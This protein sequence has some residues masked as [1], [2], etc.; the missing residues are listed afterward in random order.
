MKPGPVNERIFFPILCCLGTDIE[1]QTDE[2]DGYV[3]FPFCRRFFLG[4]YDQNKKYKVNRFN[5]FYFVNLY[6]H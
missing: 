2:R 6:I 3:F 1:E 4:I 5:T